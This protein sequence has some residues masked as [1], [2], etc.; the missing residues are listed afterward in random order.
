MR[1]EAVYYCGNRSLR[2]EAV[3]V[4]PP[5]P[6]EVQISVGFCGICGTDLLIYRGRMDERVGKR[7]I[8][9]HEM[10]GRIAALG[11]RVEG[12]AVGAPVVVRPL[13]PC[14]QCH[15]CRTGKNRLCHS[16]KVFGVDLEGSMQQLWNVP[17]RA[18]HRLPEGLALAHAALV[19]PLAVA[20]RDVRRARV[21]PG[22]DVLVIGGGPIGLL[23]ALVARKAGGTVTVSE[24]NPH[25]AQLAEE[26]G[27]PVI[28]PRRANLAAEVAGATHGKGADVVFEASG[29]QAGLDAMTEAA[30]V[31]GR[32][33]IVGM[34]LD[35]ARLNL[36]RV[37]MRE[38][39][40]IGS[41]AYEAEDFERAIELLR[42]GI[43]AERI[44]TEMRR[45]GDVGEAFRDLCENP[46]SIKT[47]IVVNGAST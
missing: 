11:E 20:V 24:V 17:A 7:R 1:G 45:L 41:R 9:G 25:R 37:T 15:P 38:L 43:A 33:C 27:F 18:V 8:I 47:L 4:Q 21:A 32:I 44:I 10:S 31:N 30:A 34:H 39:E 2:I 19:E 29:N 36:H 23:V 5:G 35:S 16:L 14:G 40:I 26:L 13:A 3:T 22:E 28:N 6:E 46:A 42:E 12:M